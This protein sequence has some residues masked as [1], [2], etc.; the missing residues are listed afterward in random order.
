[1]P[2][3]SDILRSKFP[4]EPTLGQKTV[5]ALLDQLTEKN[6]QQKICLL[7]KGYAGTGKTTIIS[8]LTDVLPLFNLRYVLMAPTGRA[9]KVM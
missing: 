9:A 5:F 8:A 1:V 3:L 6:T 2:L 4:Y 7:I